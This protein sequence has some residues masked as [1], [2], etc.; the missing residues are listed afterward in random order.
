MLGCL[1]AA[2]SLPLPKRFKD[3]SVSF[4][5]MKLQKFRYCCIELCSPFRSPA[6][7]TH[8]QPSAL[9]CSK[10]AFLLVGH[11]SLVSALRAR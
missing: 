1:R 3:D 7:L 9:K 10:S 6:R 11:G 4:G 2:A 8:G 5:S